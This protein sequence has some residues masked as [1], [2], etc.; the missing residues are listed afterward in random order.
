MC[1]LMPAPTV[2]RESGPQPIPSLA[3]VCGD[4]SPK[5]HPSGASPSSRHGAA[6]PLVPPPHPPPA[7][8]VQFFPLCPSALLLLSE[9]G[10]Q[11]LGENKSYWVE[12]QGFRCSCLP[13]PPSFRPGVPTAALPPP[14]KRGPALFKPPRCHGNTSITRRGMAWKVQNPPL[15]SLPTGVEILPREE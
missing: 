10:E 9:Q 7:P 1:S 13:L 4:C 11:K 14:P 8:F 15:P 12:F 3:A 6:L 5:P 2:Q